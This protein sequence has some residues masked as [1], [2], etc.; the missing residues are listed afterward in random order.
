[1]EVVLEFDQ[2]IK[3]AKLVKGK[4]FCKL[5][6]ESQDQVNEEFIWEN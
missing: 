3:L 6:T 5:A 2:D 1:M 4:G